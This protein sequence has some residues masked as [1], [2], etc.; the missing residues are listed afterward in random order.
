MTKAVIMA[1]WDDVPHLRDS[2][3]ADMLASFPPYQR[4]ARSKGVPMLGAG[5]IYPIEE[6]DLRCAPFAL[7]AFWPRAYGLDVGWNMTAAVF[8][9]IDRDNDV[10]YLYDEH[11]RAHAEPSTH[12]D[13]IRRRAGDWMPGVIDPA[14]RGRGQRDGEQLIKDYCDLGLRVTPAV[15]AV[16]GGIFEVYKR[17]TTGRLR[18]FPNLTNWWM[19]FRLYR[20][21]LKGNIVKKFDHAL[22]ATRYLTISG[23]PIALIDPHYLRK[24]GHA[25]LVTSEYDPLDALDR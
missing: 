23:M 19:E 6:N 9:A 24:M 4:D 18:V 14:A 25:P 1:T 15:N 16:E 12:A 7:P 21:D 22:D 20:R 11:Y 2:D 8:G 5:A 17:M 10:L 13:A 3:K